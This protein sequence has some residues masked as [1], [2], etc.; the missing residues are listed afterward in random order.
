MIFYI[1]GAM[2][3]KPN[4]NADAFTIADVRLSQQGHTVLNPAR[5]IPMVKPEAIEHED[6]LKIDFE[7]IRLCDAVFVLRN[8]EE[9]KGSK[10]EIEYAKMLDKKIIYEVEK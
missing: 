10:K 9:S 1:S 4:Y 7:M 8:S 6:Y 2:T 3:G 5:L